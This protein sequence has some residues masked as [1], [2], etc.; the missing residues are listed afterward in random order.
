MSVN[1]VLVTYNRKDCLEVLLNSLIKQ[2]Y[3]INNIFILDNNSNDGTDTL[4]S[5]YGVLD[6]VTIKHNVWYKKTF[7]G[8]V[9]HYQRNEFNTGGSGGFSKVISKALE[10]ECDYIW[11]MDDDVAPE[12]DC[13]EILCSKML[14]GVV[15][16]V[17]NRT[18]KNFQDC[19]WIS[20]DLDRVFAPGLT[21]SRKICAEHPLTRETYSVVDF[22][23]EGPLIRFDVMKK[24]GTSDPSYFIICDDTDYAT[25]VKKYGEIT[26]VTRAKLHRQLA[27]LSD[28]SSNNEQL[29]WKNYY[30]L[31]NYILF[32]KKYGTSWGARKFNAAI[33]LVYWNIRA[34][35]SKSIK[36]IKIVNMAILDGWKGKTGKTVEPGDM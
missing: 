7:Q 21:S 11:I 13:L 28:N 10:Y 9:F 32:M 15:A 19:A 2:T 31:R 26:F 16:C 35:K 29:N 30:A 20:F 1:V 33:N 4:L 24:V 23:F 3:K 22:P 18:D 6:S 14:D 36:N 17:P 27:K 8:I 25:R 5:N 34:I 12:S